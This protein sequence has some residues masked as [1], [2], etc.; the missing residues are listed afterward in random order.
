MKRFILAC[1]FVSLLSSAAWATFIPNLTPIEPGVPYHLVFVTDGSYSKSSTDI[2]TYNAIVQAEAD[3]A[4]IG[5]GSPIGDITWNVFGSTASVSVEDNT[6]LA[7]GPVF[8]LDGSMVQTTAPT[9]IYGISL[10]SPID[11]TATGVGNVDEFVWTGIDVQGW[12]AGF[13]LGSTNSVIFGVSSGTEGYSSPSWIQEDSEGSDVTAR[14][15]AISEAL[16]GG[17]A[18]P[19]PSTLALLAV[20]LIGIGGFASRHRMFPA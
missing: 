12:G 3:A 20:G 18:V 16:V 7:G 4:G 14:L 9:I 15:Y 10:L 1:T 17:P 6:S 19:E 8:K 5:V 11:L 13:E 2:A